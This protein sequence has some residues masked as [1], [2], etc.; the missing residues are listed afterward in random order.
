MFISK[1][2]KEEIQQKI[3]SLSLLA[4]QASDRAQ[5]SEEKILELSLKISGL[6][7][8]QL[9]QHLKTIEVIEEFHAINGLS[10]DIIEKIKKFDSRVDSVEGFIA[11][12]LR[13]YEDMEKEQKSLHNTIKNTTRELLIIDKKVD[14]FVVAQNMTNEK[15]RGQMKLLY[16]DQKDTHEKAFSTERL[17]NSTRAILFGLKNDVAINKDAFQNLCKIAVTRDE[18]VFVL[19]AEE[20]PTKKQN[21]K[22]RKSNS[23]KGIKLGPLLK[24]PEA[25]WGVKK[26]GTP[27][28]RPGRPSKGESK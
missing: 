27:R 25:P 14:D 17:L 24:T 22:A 19:K 3:E 5:K 9:Q 12:S 1:H 8:A 21:E 11:T 7:E 13:R 10:E 20:A 28:N 15:A 23:T 4:A 26:D 6:Q 16:N 2:E 18:P